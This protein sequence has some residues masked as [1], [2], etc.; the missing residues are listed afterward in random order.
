MNFDFTRMDILNHI[1]TTHG[2]KRYLE[3]GTF[4][5][6]C[7]KEVVAEHKVGVDPESGGTLRMTSDEFFAENTEKFELIFIDGLHH[8]DQVAKDI[9]NALK[10]IEPHGFVV[11]HDCFP[12]REKDEVQA[13]CG[14]AWRAFAHFRQDPNLDAIVGDFDWGVGIIR[15][16]ANPSPITL[17]RPFGELT[18][19]EMIENQNTWMRLT[20]SKL[21]REFC[22]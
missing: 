21:A 11:M 19:S 8:H 2:F 17:P 12:F 15:Q 22:Q 20:D 9:E 16:R 6:T 4:R 18:Y 14:T 3:I 5:D 7:F 1:I 13:R 10:R